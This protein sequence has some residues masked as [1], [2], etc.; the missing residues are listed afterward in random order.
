MGLHTSL[1]IGAAKRW[2]CGEF[3]VLAQNENGEDAASILVTVTAPPSPA[4][5]PV[6]IDISGT[7]CVLRWDPVQ[8]DGGAD[9]KHYIVEY[10]RD[11]WDVWLKAKTTKDCEVAIEDLI[12]GSRYKFRIKAENA[13]GISE[14]SEESDPFDVGGV[15]P[16]ETRNPTISISED[17]S[18][19]SDVTSP[20]PTLANT[21]GE[22]VSEEAT[23][24]VLNNLL[25]VKKL[26]QRVSSI[27]SDGLPSM[28]SIDVGDDEISLMSESSDLQRA[29]KMYADLQ[30]MSMESAAGSQEEMPD[31]DAY[32]REFYNEIRALSMETGGSIENILDNIGASSESL[33]SIIPQ[34]KRQELASFEMSLKQMIDEA[35][36]LAESPSASM[37][38]ISIR[39]QSDTK[40]PVLE[41]DERRSRKSFSQISQPD[42]VVSVIE[43][44]SVYEEEEPLP[45]SRRGVP[46][47]VSP[48]VIED[49]QP[50]V[51]K[52]EEQ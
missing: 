49:K 28:A 23:E 37:D 44:E 17:A 16:Q 31:L 4:G 51:Y 47:K 19:W 21:K 30:A 32:A 7:T 29:R 10:F 38:N 18:S 43:A 9:V 40:T 45:M 13:Y 14:E 42:S 46:T 11:V 27:E 15:Q 2:H 8:D 20:P 36:M 48:H 6:V 5:K 25:R 52:L 35:K 12:P 33:T 24:D 41:M 39:R 3:R 50:P 26:S 1:R 34:N 22:W